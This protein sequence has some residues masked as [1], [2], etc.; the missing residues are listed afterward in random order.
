MYPTVFLHFKELQLLM[1]KAEHF[2]SAFYMLFINYLLACSI[3]TATATV[4]LN[5]RVVTCANETHHL[6]VKVPT[7]LSGGD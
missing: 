3:A 1:V 2:C 5:L 6:Y 7:A 4:I